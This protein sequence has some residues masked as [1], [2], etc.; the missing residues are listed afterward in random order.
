M[1]NLTICRAAE[2]SI[3]E[4]APRWLVEG[5]W[6]ER[7]VGILGGE[8]KSCKTFL[9]LDIAVAVASG[10]PCLRRYSVPSPGPVLLFAGEDALPQVRK[11]LEGIA[12]IVGA[13]FASLDVHVITDPVLRL[14]KAE[15]RQA[16][17]EAVVRY[18]PRLIVLDPF[19][20]LHRIDENVASEVAPLLAFLRELERRYETS[21]LLVHHSRKG[22]ANARAGQ[23][24]RG[25]SELHAW[26]DSNLYLRRRDGGL[27]LTIEHRTAASTPAVPL[28]LA[29]HGETPALEVIESAPAIVSE[30][31]LPPAQR[32][33]QVLAKAAGPMSIT[34]LRAE[35]GMKTA[36]LCAELARLVTT[37]EVLRTQLGVELATL[38][39]P[40]QA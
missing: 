30:E 29:V 20:R 21:V 11:R 40:R 34:A 28:E 36:N 19:V 9:A 14:D 31:R 33:R 6:G 10:Q 27:W 23:A 35:C 18:R 12:A 32:I 3:D 25:S 24:L 22:A 16:L 4:N 38:S 1:K 17:D 37:G 7:A 26:G 39:L 15:H 2:L 5:L 8:P 13:D